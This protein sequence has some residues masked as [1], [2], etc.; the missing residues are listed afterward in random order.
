[1]NGLTLALAALVLFGAWG[2]KEGEEMEN[3]FVIGLCSI[4]TLISS[5]IFSIHLI[6]LFVLL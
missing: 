4:I 3:S 2:W 1:M 6:S 5:I